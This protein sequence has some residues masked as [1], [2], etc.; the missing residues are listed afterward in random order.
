MAGEPQF[1]ARETAS[2]G[3]AFSVRVV[4]RAKRDAI[5]GTM[6]GAL[7]VRLKAPPVEGQANEALRRLLAGCLNIPRAAVTIL[8]GESSRRKRV[9]VRGVNLE[10]VLALARSDPHESAGQKR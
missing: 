6:D 5:E 9:A 8:S 7:K 2:E 3:V 4:P 10:R 1:D